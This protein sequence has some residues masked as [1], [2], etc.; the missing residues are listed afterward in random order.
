VADQ[1]VVVAQAGRDEFQGVVDQ[2][3]IDNRGRRQREPVELS[4][5]APHAGPVA[6]LVLG[7]T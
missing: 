5:A 6:V 3:G 7:L 4:E 2:R 1:F